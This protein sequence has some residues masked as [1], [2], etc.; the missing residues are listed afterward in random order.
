[1]G[2]GMGMGIGRGQRRN[3]NSDERY[4]LGFTDMQSLADEDGWPY[5][6]TQICLLPCSL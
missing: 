1:M 5:P 6:S 3:L 2:M 4:A